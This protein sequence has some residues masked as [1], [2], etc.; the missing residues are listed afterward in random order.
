MATQTPR[1][2]KERAKERRPRPTRKES[3]QNAFIELSSKI[4]EMQNAQVEAIERSQT[5]AEELMLKMEIEQRKIDEE[6]RRRDQEFFLRMA[7]LL[8]K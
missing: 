1:Q 3:N 6:S 8:K 4:L 5:R 2:T 7:E